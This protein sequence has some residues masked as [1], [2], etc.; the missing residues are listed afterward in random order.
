MRPIDAM[1]L[2]ALRGSRAGDKVV[3]FARYGDSTLPDPLPISSYGFSWDSTRQ[4]QSFSC[5]IADNTGKLAPWLLEDPL[6]VGGSVLDLRYEVGQTGTQI[7][8]GPYRVVTNQ[9]K[10]RWLTY[11]IDERGRVN[12]G[13]AIPKDKALKFVPGGASIEI[14]AYDLGWVT[15]KDRLIAPE[16]PPVGGP[17]G[18]GLTPNTVVS[19][20]TRLMRDI[21]G[22]VVAPGVTDQSVSAN[23]IYERERMDAVQDL[24]KRIFCD[25]R[26]TGEGLLEIYPVLEQPPVATLQGGPDGLLVAVDRAQ[27]AEGLKNRFVVDGTRELEDGKSEPIRAI[28]DI[29]YGV[30]SIDGPFGRVPEF[31]SSTM[32]ASQAQADAYATQMAL[33]Q[34]SGL[35]IDL[36]VTC[37]PMPHLQHGDWVTVANPVVNGE[38]VPLVGKIKAMQLKSGSGLAPAPMELIVQC[39]YW[40]VASVIAQG[41]R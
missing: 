11:I 14:G 20:V 38:P 5:T 15:K 8:L 28:V 16:S 10:E 31:Y 17:D 19:E 6:G 26:F 3:A 1:T 41:R 7:N 25:Y 18:D 39:S 4:V 21:C 35:T 33:S 24:C 27:D 2:R 23:V 40:T 22:V 29:D 37:L 34:I 36:A 13:S 32:I 30:L 9:P 12:K